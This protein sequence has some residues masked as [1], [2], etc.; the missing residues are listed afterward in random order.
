MAD[1]N[2]YMILK[3]GRVIINPYKHLILH[4]M[5][6]CVH[7]DYRPRRPVPVPDPDWSR[8][9]AAWGAIRLAAFI[10]GTAVPKGPS[11]THSAAFM[12]GP[13]YRKDTTG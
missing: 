5:G 7:F 13:W 2:P 6:E 12:A 11:P 9:V 1:P 10:A 4:V 3:S 8:A